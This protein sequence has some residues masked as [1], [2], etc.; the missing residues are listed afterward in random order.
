MVALLSSAYIKQH[1]ITFYFP[2]KEYVPHVFHYGANCLSAGFR[3]LGLKVFAN[4]E[5]PDFEKRAVAEFEKGIIVFYVTEKNMTEGL[6]AAIAELLIGNWIEDGAAKHSGL[7][8][9]GFFLFNER[10]SMAM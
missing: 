2:E 1:G 10:I 4:V 9:M 5:H 6:M 7:A 8:G 3:E